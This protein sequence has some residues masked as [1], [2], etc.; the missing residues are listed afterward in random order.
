MEA[1]VLTIGDEIL[2][3][4][5]VDT[6]SAWIAKTF[7]EIGID[8]VEMWSIGDEA[9]TITSAIDTC[10]QKAKLVVVTGGLGP[11]KDDITKAAI[12]N[13]YGVGMKYSEDTFCHIKSILEKFGRPVSES[14]K[15]QCYMPENAELLP[16][17][18]G[19]APGML[20]QDYRGTL[21]SLP[22][23]PF[24]M[25]AIISEHLLPRLKK[26][27]VD[28]EIR[29]KTILTAGEGESVIAERIEPLLQDLPAFIKLAYLPSLGSVR[30]RLTGKHTDSVRLESLIETYIARI[31]ECL[32][33]LVYG[34]DELTLEKHLLQLLNEKSLTLSTAESCTGGYLAHRLT[35]VPGSST[36]FTGS[37]VSYCNEMKT[38]VLYVSPST[39]EQ[40][41][42]VSEAVVTEMVKGILTLTGSNIGV[43]ISG[44]AGP[45]GGTA[46]KPVGTIW[47]AIGNGQHLETRMLKATKDRNKNIEY[48][49]NIAMNFI[50]KFVK[51]YY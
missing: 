5:V 3:G 45:D 41:G 46:E 16:N 36:Y 43:A 12:A 18:M 24:E 30:L 2:I 9:Q 26:L 13:Y 47:L 44:I 50:R 28:L 6:N 8:V 37:V 25:K 38:K 39:L 15:E 32:G 29:H 48:A 21:V 17:S 33:D 1:I 27:P 22:G 31:T 35:S 14:H 20:F 23:V 11:T 51:R 49:A 7:N 4:Q 19:T 34:F 40:F 10:F 42:A